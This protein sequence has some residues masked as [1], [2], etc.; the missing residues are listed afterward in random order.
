MVEV[1]SD[2]LLAI[3]IGK[4]VDRTCGDNAD[5]RRTETL[6][7][8]TGRL[9]AVDITVGIK[10]RYTYCP[11]ESRRAALRQGPY[12]PKDMASFHEIPQQAPRAMWEGSY[13]TTN[14]TD[15]SMFFPE[16]T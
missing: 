3:P 9:I 11:R 2:D 10:G 16:Q 14:H 8:C 4:E 1:I 5:Q 7:Q 15:R 13:P 6:E 12:V